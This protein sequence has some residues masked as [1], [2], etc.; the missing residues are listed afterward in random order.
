MPLVTK[1]AR[2]V[3]LITLPE[4]RGLVVA[5]A[6]SETVRDIRWRAVHDRAAL[7]RDLR[8]PANA[9]DV[10]RGAARHPASRELAN[11]SLMFLPIRHLPL[12][13]AAT[14][15]MRRVLRRYL[16]P[17]AELPDAA[18]Q[19]ADRVDREAA[20]S[21]PATPDAGWKRGAPMRD[22]VQQR[23]TDMTTPEPSSRRIVR[24]MVSIH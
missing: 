8:N 13:W 10:V 15:A 6:R 11:A 16:D 24:W 12:G 9:R 5:G 1:L 23:W 19:A 4:T 3:R 18:V 20:G 7:V 17:P 21:G 22:A 2:V 14:W